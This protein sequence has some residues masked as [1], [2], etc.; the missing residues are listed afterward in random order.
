MHIQHK[1]SVPYFNESLT[2]FSFYRL[3]NGGQF[4]LQ[5]SCGGHTGLQDSKFSS[6]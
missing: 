2:W 6:L 1:N 4:H 3:F 5:R